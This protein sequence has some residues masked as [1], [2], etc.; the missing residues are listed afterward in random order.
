MEKNPA[1]PPPPPAAA[2][3]EG[4]GLAG[5]PEA[6]TAAGMDDGDHDSGV[7]S[8]GARGSG[9]A[10]VAAVVAETTGTPRSELG[11]ETA[12]AGAAESPSRESKGASEEFVLSA[13]GSDDPDDVDMDEMVDELGVE[14]F[15]S[16]YHIHTLQSTRGERYSNHY[17][18]VCF[19][20]VSAADGPE[21]YCKRCE[22]DYCY[23]CAQRERAD[24]EQA[25]MRKRE[26]EIM[27]TSARHIH[28]LQGES[29]RRLAE[30]ACSVCKGLCR[31][32][33]TIAYVCTLC[34]P[35]FIMVSQRSAQFR[36][37]V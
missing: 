22:F 29:G 10:T 23:D 17:C 15:T 12:P 6:A 33:G 13:D 1:P 2:G 9:E 18:D 35:E 26:I 3:G 28:P 27:R 14:T 32:K 21:Y 11:S 31:D 24:P 5:E 8:S 4:R 19:N 7:G 34:E 16:T 25:A 30:A 36:W 20:R 37:C